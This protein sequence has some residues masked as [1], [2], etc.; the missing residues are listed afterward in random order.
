MHTGVNVRVK[1]YLDYWDLVLMK[2]LSMNIFFLFLVKISSIYNS[3]NGT[4]CAERWFHLIKVFGIWVLRKTSFTSAIDSVGVIEMKPYS[5]AR[6]CFC[7]RPQSR[8]VWHGKPENL[9]QG[10]QQ[11]PY[12][13]RF[14]SNYVV[15][16]H[17]IFCSWYSS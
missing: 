12:N 16:P 1:I 6:R 4:G 11:I 7:G 3:T 8:S 17:C 13:Y 5:S 2:F 15:V 9:S 10:S 14:A